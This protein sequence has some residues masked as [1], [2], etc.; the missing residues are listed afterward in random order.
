MRI[1]VE[2]KLFDTPKETFFMLGLMYPIQNYNGTRWIVLR[3]KLGDSEH[4]LTFFEERK[5]GT[6]T[7]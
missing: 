4:E 6:Q 2:V 5:N 3:T 1:K 7:N